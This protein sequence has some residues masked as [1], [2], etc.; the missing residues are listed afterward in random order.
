MQSQGNENR[1]PPQVTGANNTPSRFA[2]PGGLQYELPRS[3]ASSAGTPSKRLQWSDISHSSL[4]KKESK[5]VTSLLSFSSSA[6]A[7]RKAREAMRQGTPWV[8]GD[9]FCKDS[10]EDLGLVSP[11]RLSSVTIVRR[12][13]N[14]RFCGWVNISPNVKCARGA[15][16][17][18]ST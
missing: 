7:L 9:G 2:R 10:L 18:L 5:K 8:M 4:A 12:K 3:P 13:L 15:C 6:L 14:A 17:R 16:S 1:V 11:A